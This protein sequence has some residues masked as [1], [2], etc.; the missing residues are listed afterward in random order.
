MRSVATLLAVWLLLGVVHVQAAE[1]P[2]AFAWLGKSKSSTES[3][4]GS[5]LK[6]PPLLTKMSSG[7]K[8]VVTGTKNLVTPKKPPKKTSGVV[9][10]RKAEKSRPPQQSMLG[11][12]FNPQPTQPPST[13]AE[14]MSLEQVKPYGNAKPI[15]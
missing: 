3:A 12:I 10:V 2:S 14:W 13:V 6:M 7:T 5:G 11:R 9:A 15:R 1:K 4:K 8:R